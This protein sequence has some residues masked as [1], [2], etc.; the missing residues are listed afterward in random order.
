MEKTWSRRLF[1]AALC[2][3]GVAVAGPTRCDVC[4]NRLSRQVW[5]YDG[6]TLCSEACVDQLRPICSVCGTIIRG[7]YT[8]ANG[9]IYC[10][11]ACLQ[12]TLPKCEICGSPIE[13][14]FTIT[15]H[16]YCKSCVEQQPV[17]FSCGLPAAHP[18]RLKDGREICGSCM[19][20]AVA[21][22]ERAQRHYEQARKQLET[23]TAL[24]IETVP[25]LVLVDRDEMQRLSK[26][27]RKTDTPVSIR[28]LYS[29][30]VMMTKYGR[31]GAWKEEPAQAQEKIYI[32]DHL[33]DEVFRVAAT[34]ELMHDLIH[35]NFPRL[36]TAPMWVHEGICQQAAAEYCRRRNYADTLQGIEECADPDYGDGYRYIH[37]LSGIQGWS[38][39]CHWMETVDVDALPDTV[40]K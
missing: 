19:R 10:S 39:L 13:T 17:C 27:I 30:Q 7:G 40:P 36:G 34:H 32:V 11:A 29:R 15:R 33:S 35:E 38:A 6:K 12:T 24:T 21:T 4:G 3:T 20:W 5:T 16:H 8:E 31:F 14:G 18:S 26:E 9:H 23:W 28:G 2:C 22:Q 37:S 1:T 25:E